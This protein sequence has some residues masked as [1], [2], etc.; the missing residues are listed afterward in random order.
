LEC[1]KISKELHTVL[2]ARTHL[3]EGQWLE[4]Q[5]NGEKLRMFREGTRIPTVS[6]TE[7]QFITSLKI[8]NNNNNNNNN[9]NKPLNNYSSW[10]Q[11]NTL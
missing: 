10:K 4:E 8:H 9:S 2:A 6:W 3:A 7:G 5:Q 11:L 1:L